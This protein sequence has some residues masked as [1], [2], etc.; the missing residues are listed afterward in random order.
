[1]QSNTV[2]AMKRLTFDRL[3]D[4]LETIQEIKDQ[5]LVRDR[6]CGAGK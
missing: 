2:C 6:V 5:N 3:K 1:V 4:T